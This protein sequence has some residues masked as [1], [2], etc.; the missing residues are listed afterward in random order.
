MTPVGGAK[1]TNIGNVDYNALS[2]AELQG[3]NYGTTPIPGNTTAP[4]QLTD[5]DV[6]AVMTNAGNLTKVKVVDYDY[7]MKI[8]WATYKLGPRYRVLGTGYNQPEDIK[9]TSGGRYAYVTERTGNLLRVDLTNA[10]RA[11]ATVVASGM[12][13]PHQIALDEDHSQ[14]YVI[15]FAGANSHLW[16]IDLITGTKTAVVS[17]LDS[18]IGLLMT[19]D[20]RYAYVSQ[21]TAGGGKIRRINMTNGQQEL[22]PLTLTSPFFMT[23]VDGGESAILIAERDPANRITMIDLTKAPVVAT[24]VAAGVATRPSSVAVMA[25]NRILVCSDQEV[26][27]ID[28][29]GGIFTATGPTLLGVGHV[30]KTS[31]SPDGYATT[32]PGY[33]F[34]VKDAPFG[35]TLPMMF[36]HEKARNLGAQYYQILVDGVVQSQPWSDYKWS[37]SANTFQLT[38]AGQNGNFFRVRQA[39]E[40]WLNYWLGYFLD[41]TAFADGAHTVA[42]KIFT[43]PNP[44][45]EIAAGADSAL[46]RIDNQWPR[47][48]IEEIIHH[49]P[50]NPNPALQHQVVGTCGIVQ[51]TSDEFSLKIEAID[52]AGQHLLNW[53]LGVLWG[54]NKSAAIAGDSYEPG[55]VSPTKKWSGIHS[56][57]P[58][59]HWHATVPGDPTSRRC[60]HTFTLDVWDR[61]I[62]GW[63]Y[64]HYSSYRK[65]ITLLLS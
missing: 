17:N 31:I 13:A 10:N 15:E 45:S 20:F 4:N 16:R 60:A 63:N 61:T 1:I 19:G 42:F 37:T 14:A 25:P 47:A 52:P 29:L 26:D 2:H 55:H 5:G 28:L 8:E 50:A 12:T 51:G 18:C 62:N 36:N 39:G 57:V 9:V 49:D 46:L 30:P 44:A 48:T 54:D 35:G 33:F 40:I 64:I 24:A 34:K 59:A 27:Q 7:N 56:E 58:P 6:F 41:T 65:S 32:D 22:L 3:F 11:A 38:A 23:W 43:A 53:S 21:Q